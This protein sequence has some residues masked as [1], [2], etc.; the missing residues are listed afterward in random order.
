[1]RFAKVGER[2]RVLNNKNGAYK[3]MTGEV[4][5]VLLSGL[6]VVAID[7]EFHKNLGIG[8]SYTPNIQ[9][10]NYEILAESISTLE[11]E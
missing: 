5:R 8:Y 1:M 10:G 6:A 3:N 4:I 9:F 2:V 11:V 7:S